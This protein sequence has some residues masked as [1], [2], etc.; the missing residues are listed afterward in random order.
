MSF[1]LFYLA[2]IGTGLNADLT[3]VDYL[4]TLPEHQRRGVGGLLLRDGLKEADKAGVKTIVMASPVGV[5]LYKK[6][7]FEHVRTVTQ[8]DSPYGG[9]GN[10]Q[11]FFMVRQPL[12]AGKET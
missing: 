2:M 12:E 5:N 6:Y 1:Y 3:A 11:Q 7:G 9:D 10:Y 8:D 4:T